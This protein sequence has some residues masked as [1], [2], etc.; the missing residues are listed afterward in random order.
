M[1]NEQTPAPPPPR[2]QPLT[3]AQLDEL[4][5]LLRH[6]TRRPWEADGP[7]LFGPN[8]DDTGIAFDNPVD[9]GLIA[10]AVN[11]LPALLARFRNSAPPA[12]P[13]AGNADKRLAAAEAACRFVMSRMQAVGNVGPAD[14]WPQLETVTVGGATWDLLRK[15][16]AAFR[17]AP[18]APSTGQLSEDD[19]WLLKWS[20]QATRDSCGLERRNMLAALYERLGLDIDGESAAPVAPAA[21]QHDLAD[22]DNLVR[23][24]LAS[25][26]DGALHIGEMQAE[27]IKRLRTQLA[28]AAPAPRA[29]LT[30]ADR[31]LLTRAANRLRMKGESEC[32]DDVISLRDRLLL[33]PPAEAAT[34]PAGAAA[35]RLTC[36][37]CGEDWF[38]HNP[39]DGTCD[40]PL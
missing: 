23:V 14:G 19:V 17:A 6:A 24:T 36:E 34:P 38:S 28:A 31:E 32:G 37:K 22:L 1:T 40:L 18:V 25:G 13:N 27:E 35:P 4:E 5:R 29:A 7:V 10:A 39:E 15:W 12:A 16:D 33:T 2:Q 21:P 9:A 8:D 3:D 30:A 26:G 11:A 20:L